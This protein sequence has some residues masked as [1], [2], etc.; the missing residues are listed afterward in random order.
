[1]DFLWGGFGDV[2]GG[3]RDSSCAGAWR[4]DDGGASGVIDGEVSGTG[5]IAG[6][7]FTCGEYGFGE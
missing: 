3:G 7:E 5:G 4:A 1:L 6:D 2:G